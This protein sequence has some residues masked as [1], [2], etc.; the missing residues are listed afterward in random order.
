MYYYRKCILEN[1]NITC[2]FYV[3]DLILFWIYTLSP[4]NIL[5]T[6]FSDLA[7][8]KPKLNLMFE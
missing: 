5:L 4:I 1:E 6:F 8:K 7:T 2:H 3:T